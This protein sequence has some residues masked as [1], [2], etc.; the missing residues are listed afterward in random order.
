MF[1]ELSAAPDLKSPRATTSPLSLSL[2]LSF[3]F[4]PLA[5]RVTL[6][7]LYLPV[8]S[9]VHLLLR[10]CRRATLPRRPLLSFVSAQPPCLPSRRERF[11]L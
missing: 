2:F 8:A 6:L 4:L 7:L 9:P 10:L 5:P 11:E 3:S 1:R